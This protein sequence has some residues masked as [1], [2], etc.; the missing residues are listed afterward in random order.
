MGITVD[1]FVIQYAD[2]L[3]TPFATPNIDSYQSLSL[4]SSENK[5]FGGGDS[6]KM[7][8]RRC[9]DFNISRGRLTIYGKRVFRIEDV[10]FSY[11]RRR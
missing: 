8:T 6:R 5:Q 10:T 3:S 9:F 7:S 1:H 2:T 11:F 4:C